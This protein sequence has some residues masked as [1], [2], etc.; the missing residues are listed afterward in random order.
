MKSVRRLDASR[1]Y[2]SSYISEVGRDFYDN[3]LDAAHPAWRE[4]GVTAADLVGLTG[5]PLNTETE[6]TMATWL[7]GQ[8]LAD[9]E[10]IVSLFYA[11]QRMGAWV[12]V[13]PL[14][15]A[16]SNACHMFPLNHRRVLAHLITLPSACRRTAQF[17]T[18]IITAEWPELLAYPFNHRDGRFVL[19]QRTIRTWNRLRGRPNRG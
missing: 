5:A 11:E 2:L 18:D 1:A 13:L 15:Y 17:N 8:P 6:S 4:E 14:S 19:R 7:A 10:Q 9:P 16:D 3:A 12:S